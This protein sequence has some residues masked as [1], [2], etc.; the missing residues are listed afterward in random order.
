MWKLGP[1]RVFLA[2]MM[3]SC[4]P[5][6][7]TRAG[8]FFRKCAP[9]SDCN[10][11]VVKIPGHQIVVETA[12]PQVVVNEARVAKPRKVVT[13]TVQAPV[14]TAA[15]MMAAPMVAT[16]FTPMALPAVHAAPLTAAPCAEKSALD[17][18][19]AMEANH[20]EIRKLQAARDLELQ[21]AN[22]ALKRM[23]DSIQSSLSGTKLSANGDSSDIRTQL[24]AEVNRLNAA[25]SGTN[26]RSTRLEG[27]IKELQQ[28]VIVH[29]EVI[30]KK[31]LGT[32][33]TGGCGGTDAKRVEDMIRD[34]QKMVLN[35]DQILQDMMRQRGAALPPGPPPAAGRP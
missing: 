17:A 10:T 3:L 30:K 31:V 4:G 19:H 26:D 12:R 14:M 13:T 18:V 2:G 25:I 11:E 7:Y 9:D 23:S 32:N 24:A 28:L 35:H 6:S 29:D 34:L 8:D 15:P 20:L 21:H 1:V 33:G 5:A 22:M 27:L 16:I